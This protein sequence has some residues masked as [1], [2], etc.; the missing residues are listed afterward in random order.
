MENLF[1]ALCSTL[2]LPDNKALF[3]QAEGGLGGVGAG[4]RAQPSRAAGL[5]HSV[6]HM[7][8]ARLPSLHAAVP[9]QGTER[10]LWVRSW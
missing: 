9:R 2:L 7:R 1:D 10:A 3:V 6:P 5:G 4:G 8:F